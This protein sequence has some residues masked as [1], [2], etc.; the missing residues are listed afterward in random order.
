MKRLF[1]TALCAAVL[2]SP[3]QEPAATSS[4]I[5]AGGTSTKAGAGF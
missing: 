4:G 1:A 3:A 2:A 5:S